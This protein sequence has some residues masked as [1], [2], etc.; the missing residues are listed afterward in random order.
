MKRL[1]LLVLAL[2]T[3]SPAL[4]EE[5][6][7]PKHYLPLVEQRLKDY[8]R[9]EADFVYDYQVSP[10]RVVDL[11]AATEAPRRRYVSCVRIGAYGTRK[12]RTETTKAMTWS[13]I[14]MVFAPDGAEIEEHVAFAGPDSA[15]RS[16]DPVSEW[17]TFCPLENYRDR[18][19]DPLFED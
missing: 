4:A 6:L 14:A 16:A 5:P 8:S 15:D 19:P 12:S 3:A 2:L 18:E 17:R 7:L 9:I 13:E 1:S 10:P 11:A